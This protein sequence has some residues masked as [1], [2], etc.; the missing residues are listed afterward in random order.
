M[1]I[2]AQVRLRIN[3][4]WRYAAEELFG[5]GYDS[6]YKLA[7]G[8]P[9]STITAASATIR[10]ASS[11]SGTGASFDASLGLVSFSGVISALSAFRAVY[12]WAVF[13]DAEIAQFISDG[14]GS[15]AG[16]SLEAVRGLMFDHLKR[17]RW[18]APDGTQYDDTQSRVLLKQMYDMLKQEIDEVPSGGI[19]AWAEQ[20]QYY[21]SAEYSA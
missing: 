3:D 19:E 7:Q 8:Q 2:T 4:K 17:A 12:Q 21:D 13:S 15:V 11:Y 20:Q 5:N 10:M 1:D 18:S 16:A 14:G 6:T 9:Y